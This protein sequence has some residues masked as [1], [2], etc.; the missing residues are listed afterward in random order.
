MGSINAFESISRKIDVYVGQMPHI[1]SQNRQYFKEKLKL[2]AV[3]ASSHKIYRRAVIS[4]T[5]LSSF[6]AADIEAHQYL[7]FVNC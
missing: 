2:L 4:V 3:A 5:L 6:F 7:T 1:H